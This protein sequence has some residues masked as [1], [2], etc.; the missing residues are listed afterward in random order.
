M[1][2]PLYSTPLAFD[3]V[4]ED[5]FSSLSASAA[6][7]VGAGVQGAGSGVEGK[8][9]TRAKKSLDRLDADPKQP[10]YSFGTTQIRVFLQV[11]LV[12]YCHR[13]WSI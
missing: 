9:M 10:A 6:A 11:C 12:H 4:A 13:F 1:Q 3:I 2:D 5:E 7:G 8:V